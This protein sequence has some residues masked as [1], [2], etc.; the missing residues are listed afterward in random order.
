MKAHNLSILFFISFLVFLENSEASKKIKR[1][2]AET[3]QCSSKDSFITE[4]GPMSQLDVEASD[5][6]RKKTCEDY[7]SR[8]RGD[9]SFA[10]DI[11]HTR[12]I[13]KTDFSFVLEDMSKP[14][15]LEPAAFN[16]DLV[17]VGQGP[18]LEIAQKKLNLEMKRVNEVAAERILAFTKK[19][20]SLG[21]VPLA[22]LKS[23]QEEKPKTS[24]NTS[25]ENRL[26][27]SLWVSARCQPK[28]PLPST[29]KVDVMVVFEKINSNEA[30]K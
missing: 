28:N 23:S 15:L 3:E 7:T 14:P 8:Y 5:A 24:K 16:Q 25:T 29:L 30:A 27:A 26:E 13:C 18:T 12:E 17:V 4:V 1:N 10:N 6:L 20:E 9:C 11:N 2:P 21:G 19:C 22:K